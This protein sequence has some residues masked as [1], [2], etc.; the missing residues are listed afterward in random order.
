[1]EYCPSTLETEVVGANRCCDRLGV[2]QPHPRSLDWLGQIFLG[3]EHMHKRLDIL[4]RDP[5]LSTA[6]T[7]IA[8]KLRD[9]QM[10]LMI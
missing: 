5:W 4:F 8:Q 2:Y 6:S 7:L 1:M 10:N 9:K 3:L